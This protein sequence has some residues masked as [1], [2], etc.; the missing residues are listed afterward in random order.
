MF[1]YGRTTNERVFVPGR[2]QKGVQL[3][4]GVWFRVGGG[5]EVVASQKLADATQISCHNGA[6]AAA[7]PGQDA[8][9]TVKRHLLHQ[10]DRNPKVNNA[11]VNVPEAALAVVA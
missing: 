2:K 11:M 6:R 7:S 5:Q 8:A 3:E 9:S 1:G 10:N 4:D